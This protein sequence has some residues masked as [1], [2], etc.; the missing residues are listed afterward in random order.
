MAAIQDNKSQFVSKDTIKRLVKDVKDIMKN[1]LHDSGIYYVHSDTDM[2]FGKALIIGPP[3]TPYEGGYYLFKFEFPCDYPHNPPKVTYFTNDGATRFNPNLYKSGKVCVSILNTWRGPQWTGCQTISST[4][5]CLCSAVL[6]DQP[7]LNEPGVRS[8]NPD[9]QNYMDIITYKNYEVA[10]CGMLV[11]D[12][13][14]NEFPELHDIMAKHFCE[15]YAAILGRITRDMAK[16]PK[17]ERI[18]TTK[19]YGMKTKIR[20]TI[21]KTKIE[22]IYES[23]TKLN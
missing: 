22:E 20:Y 2:M 9:Y 18:V 10:I 13:I 19:I 14:M 11:R 17:A 7:L 8:D 23:L 6:N 21:T 3:N 5:L 16:E 15:N 1:P 12:N 4:L